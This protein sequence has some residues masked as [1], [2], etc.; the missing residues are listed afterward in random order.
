MTTPVVPLQRVVAAL[1][2]APE[3]ERVLRRAAQI[4]ASLN[5]ELIGVH[6]REPSGLTQAEPA[7]LPGQ[8]RILGELGGRY[9]EL[10][11]IDVARAV[12]DFAR[13]EDAHHLV[14]GATR[15]SRRQE[16]L[17]GSVINKAVRTAGPVEIHIVPARTPSREARP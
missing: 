12:L 7:W 15:R 8:R 13:S 11:G 10:A 16:L 5:G 17:H 6:V 14:L 3:G 1:T 4:A 9:T 2:G